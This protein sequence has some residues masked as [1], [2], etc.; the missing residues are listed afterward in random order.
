[1]RATR[2]L[3]CAALESRPAR[4]EALR[5]FL[6]LLVCEQLSFHARSGFLALSLSLSLS[7]S[8]SLTCSS[9][10]KTK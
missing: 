7:L 1:M 5:R 6:V 10:T 9:R 3:T 4:R 2:L 8:F